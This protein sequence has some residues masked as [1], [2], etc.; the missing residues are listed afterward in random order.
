[1]ETRTPVLVFEGDY[2]LA[3]VL[4]SVL[5]NEGIEVSFDDLP[6]GTGRGRDRSR[7]YVRRADE[8]NARRV[9]AV[10][11]AGTN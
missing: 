9:I 1:M 8:A 5:Q 6:I 11:S 3:L 10:A 7:I 4:V 2:S